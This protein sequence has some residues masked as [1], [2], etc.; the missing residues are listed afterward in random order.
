MCGNR[1]YVFVSKNIIEFNLSGIAGRFGSGSLFPLYLYPEKRKSESSTLSFLEN[2][3]PYVSSDSDSIR[4]NKESKIVNLKSNK[5]DLISMTEEPRFA[6]QSLSYRPNLSQKIVRALE[7]SLGMSFVIQQFKSNENEFGE[8][9]ILDYIYSVLHSP[10]Y[11]EKYKEFL[12][13]DFPR[14]PYPIDQQTFWQMVKLGGE[15]RQI[16]LLESPVVEKYITQYPIGGDN[17]VIKIKFQDNKVFIN[18]TQY[19]ANVPGIAWDF[20]IGGYSQLR[21]GSKTV[22]AEL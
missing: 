11:R 5:D 19:F 1:K 10:T 14:I 22:K 17:I 18:E 4:L 3:E 7:K 15:L 2:T 20:Y 6:Y 12:K 8:V 13:I 9:D 16:H 21:N